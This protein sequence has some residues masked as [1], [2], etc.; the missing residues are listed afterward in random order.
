MLANHR[1]AIWWSLALLAAA[2]SVFA[3]VGRHPRFAAPA[4]SLPIVGEWDLAMYRWMDGPRSDPLTLLARF[5]S[6]LGSGVVTIPVR[7]LVSAWLAFRRWWRALAAWLLT[8]AAAELV[9]AVAKWFF[10]RGRPAGPLVG[11]VGFSFPSGHTVAAAATAVAL[12]LVLLPPGRARR[13]WEVAA[14]GFAFLMAFSRVYLRA[15]WPSDVVGGILLGTGVAL[16]AAG[17][18]TEIR[19]IPLRA[20][21]PAAAAS[22]TISAEREPASRPRRARTSSPAPPPAAATRP[23]RAR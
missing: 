15:H 3:A 16:G 14:I 13:R 9:L 22:G 2:A 21:A 11:T 4:T 6:I 5:L 10:H 18:V 17:L 1:R 23:S 19:D 20:T 8:W 7:V 12:V